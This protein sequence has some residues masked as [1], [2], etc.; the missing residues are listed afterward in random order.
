MMDFFL[1][2]I[3]PASPGVKL[4][5]I[6][7]TVKSRFTPSPKIGYFMDVTLRMGKYHVGCEGPRHASMGGGS[8]VDNIYT[9][10]AMMRGYLYGPPIE[11]LAQAEQSETSVT[12][13]LTTYEE[14]GGAPETTVATTGAIGRTDY[15]SYYGANLQDPAYQ[16]YTPPYFYGQSSIYFKYVVPTPKPATITID[17]QEVLNTILDKTDAS[18]TVY[19]ERYDTGSYKGDIDALCLTVPELHTVSIGSLTRTKVDS[20][21]DISPNA[22]KITKTD[23]DVQHYVSYVAPKWV[24]PVL[25]FSSS[26][27]V[28]VDRVY[29]PVLDKFGPSTSTLTNTYHDITTGRGLWGGYGIDP[30]D[31]EVLAKM[32]IESEKK[33]KGVYLSVGYP[34]LQSQTTA[35]QTYGYTTPYV[36]SGDDFYSSYA[37][38]GSVGGTE[39][40]N[41]ALT[42]SLAQQLGFSPSESRAIGRFAAKKDISEAVVIIPYF[43]NSIEVKPRSG[44][45]I[46]GSEGTPRDSRADLFST[47]EI[48]P[49][50]HFLPINRFLF[51]RLLAIHLEQNPVWSDSLTMAVP[52][53]STQGS[54][55]QTA[56][57]LAINRAKSTD[58]YRMIELL[59]GVS[60]KVDMQIKKST[61]TVGYQLPPEFDFIFNSAIDPFQMVV[62]P[63][64][65]KLYKQELIDIYQGIMPRSSID[66][67]RVV[68]SMVVNPRPSRFEDDNPWYPGAN[69]NLSQLA[70]AQFL[71][72]AVFLESNSGL[73]D[74]STLP[75][76]IKSSADFYKNVKFMIFKAK[77]RAKKDYP[78]Y[79]N[80]QIA[81]YVRDKRLVNPDF[82]SEQIDRYLSAISRTEI[83]GA[84][85]PY[86]Y[87]S[88]LQ[89]AKIDISFLV[90]GTTGGGF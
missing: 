76:A 31:D 53:S 67:E 81:K 55:V 64:D 57:P 16:A 72:P 54:F 36:E 73:I 47:R 8:P 6:A 38:A 75:D 2:D 51:K 22:L 1:E 10:N 44:L 32:N 33:D 69:E 45:I 18:D 12:E 21:V 28:V 4:P 66:L 83:Q 24:C 59:A 3:D 46:E 5:I 52:G 48:I 7:S 41:P 14:G 85:W 68:K 42:A 43:E 78:I 34:F 90:D 70:L 29:D 56:S 71:T 27:P 35:Q 19:Y 86:D 77:Q 80:K 11:Y 84:N 50:K 25:D 63:I 49:G 39:T 82:K 62:I 88:L 40:T 15:Q 30:Y 17:V 58:V 23:S 9:R 74:R 87:F 60:A 61:S 89:S 79:R 37:R 20:S 26:S 65:H 13:V